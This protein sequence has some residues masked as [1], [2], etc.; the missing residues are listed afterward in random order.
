MGR[1]GPART[2]TKVLQ[3][4]GS[5]R[6]KRREGEP[7]PD[8][9]AP[10]PPP[11]LSEKARATWDEL[12]PR[13]AAIGVATEVDG[14]A[15]GRYCE[16]WALW[17]ELS[18]FVQKSGHAHPVKNKRGDIVGVKAYPQVRLLLQTSE[19]LLRLEQQF[20]LTPAARAHLAVDEG[21]R[22]ESDASPFARRIG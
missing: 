7:E 5:W 14:R 13:L 12:M 10:E 11:G 15:F 19:H 20:G 3:L 1:R 2:P 8:A 9:V 21:P 4:R 22:D 6:A 16:T 18:A 17:T